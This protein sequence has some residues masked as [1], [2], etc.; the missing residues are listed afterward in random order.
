LLHRRVCEGNYRFVKGEIA[1]EGNI[2]QAGIY[3]RGDHRLN[4]NGGDGNWSIHGVDGQGY[5]YLRRCRRWGWRD[6]IVDDCA[7][8]VGVRDRRVDSI[9][10]MNGE[11]LV[12]LP[13][14]IAVN[15][16]SNVLGGDIWRKKEQALV[17]LVVAVGQG[18]GAILSYEVDRCGQR[19]GAG[20]GDGEDELGGFSP[21]TFGA[22]HVINREGNR[23][24][25]EEDGCVVSCAGVVGCA[26]VGCREILLAIAVEIAYGHG[27][28]TIAKAEVGRRTESPGA[29]AQQNR[30]AGWGGDREVLLAVTIKITHRCFSRT[31]PGIEVGSRTEPSGP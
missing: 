17:E 18:C 1:L 27:L 24:L 11:R 29:I 22:S 8:A 12:R 25:P 9:T 21:V 15:V 7:S 4:D 26:G 16:H 5:L 2:I 13:C 19:R 23:A 30:H 6:V 14:I 20:F 31:R 28:T 3:E 10:E